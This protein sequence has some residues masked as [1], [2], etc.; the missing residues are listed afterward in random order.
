MN[1]TI[2]AEFH[3]LIPLLKAQELESLTDS[4]KSEGCRDA[5][6]V[7]QGQNILLDGHNRYEICNR[8]GITFRIVER[9]FDSR[10]DAGVWIC[11]N[12]AGRRNLEPYASI[13]LE[14]RRAEYLKQKAALQRTRKPKQPVN[15]EESVLPMLAKQNEPIDVRKTVAKRAGV[16]NGTAAKAFVIEAKADD[17]TKAQLIAGKVS[18]DKVY[19]SIVEP[20]KRAERTA[21]LI[22][23][24]QITGRFP[25]ILADPPWRYEHS[26][27]NSRE[28]ENQYPTMSL[29]EI[30]ALPV[31]AAALDD[32]I[33]FL[34]ATSPKLAE[35]ME[36]LRAWGFEYRTCAVWDKEIIGPG[37][38]FRQQH[39]LLL[40][41]TKGHPVTP[42][43]SQRVS[44]V[45]H[46]RRTTTHSEKPKIVYEVI[47]SYFPEFIAVGLLLELF[48]RQ[49]RKGWK[50]WG[51]QLT[52]NVT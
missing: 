13:M 46:A 23:P 38:Y 34:W 36:V 7:W 52:S 22:D 17:E 35:S 45:I 5:L 24:G 18:I 41:A 11:E 4:L 39:E 33:L 25:I 8:E 3:S 48:Q 14:K 28:I 51:N 37:Y 44:S 10:E 49:P 12:Q 26:T 27:S 1:L 31:N 29:A 9:A 6:V 20:E 50:G 42:A 15:A 2:D 43:P 47:E 19:R 30:C 40:V 16:S 32:C 21:A